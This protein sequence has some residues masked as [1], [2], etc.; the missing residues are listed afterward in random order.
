MAKQLNQVSVNLAFT[1][2]TKQAKAQ[3]QD[4]Q[5]QLKTIT[6]TSFT[7]LGLKNDVEGAVK[8]AAQLSTHLQKATNVK[9]GTLD[10]SKLN[11][12]LKQSGVSLDEYASKLRTLGP[13]GQ[14]AFMSLTQSVAN[15]EVPL[16]RT[17]ALLREMGTT[18]ANTARWQIS[19][20][21]LHG[22]MGAIQSAYGYAQD[23][24]ES[25]NNI[26]IVTGQ[27]TDQM[28]RFANEAQQAA[29][30]L[31][32]TTTAYTNASLIYYQQGLNEQQVKE[33]ADIT[34][35]MANIARESAEVVSDQLTAVWN[36]FY[37]EGGQSLEHYADAM[38]ALGAATASSTSE[39]AG[40]LE[41]FAS[42]ADMIGLSF[43]NAS[44]ALA[45]ITATTRQSEDVV[46]TALKTI[47]AR[48]QGLSL[49][50]TLEDGTNLNKY[51]EALNKVG[52]SIYDAAG[53]L[54]DMD[55][56]LAEMGAKWETLN[57]DQQVALAQ[58][59]AGV[60]QY[61]QLVS[62]MDNFDF[63][64]QNLRTAQNSDGTLNAQAE[65]YAESWEAAQKR[66][67]A[68]AEGVFNSLLKDDFFIDMLNNIEK[69]ISFV[70]KLIDSLG[71][72]KGVLLTLG[73]ILTKTFSAQ[74]AQN[75][76]SL[77]YN[78][79]MSTKVGRESEAKQKKAF[80][81]KQVTAIAQDPR[82]ATLTEQAQQDA[83]RSQLTLQQQLLENAEKMSTEELEQN[84]ILI[85]RNRILQEQR[86]AAVKNT[87]NAVKNQDT[88]VSDI[89]GRGFT[90]GADVKTLN[91]DIHSLRV[92]ATAIDEISNKFA[93][94]GIT[95][96]SS[97]AEVQELK[98]QIGALKTGDGVIDGF[99]QDFMQLEITSNNAGDEIQELLGRIKNLSNQKLSNIRSQIAST[100]TE[101]EITK[102]LDSLTDSINRTTVA[103]R[104]ERVAT[105]AAKRANDSAVE[106]IQ[107]AKGAQSTWADTLVA[108]AG[109][110]MNAAMA[111]NMVGSVF[112]TIKDPDASGWEKFTS[113]LMTLG[114][115]IPTLISL[116]SSLK[117]IIS[118]ETVAK[119][120]NA[121]ATVAQYLAEKKLNQEKRK[122]GKVTRGNTQETI[123][124]TKEKI[125]DTWNRSALNHNKN[126]TRTKSG[127]YAV[128]GQKGFVSE[129]KAIEMAGKSATKVAKGFGL[130]AAG[131][132]LATTAIIVAVNT[133]NKHN[134]AAEEA[135]KLAV[136]ASEAYE[137]V[138]SA[139]NKFTS[140]LSAYED[141]QNGMKN[142]TRGTL[143][144]KEAVLK[145]N[146]ASM[147]LL[148]SYEDLQYTVD[149]DGLIKI[150]EDSLEDAKEAQMDL[151]KNAQISKQVMNQNARDA[152]LKADSKTFQRKKM[153][154]SSDDGSQIGNIAAA[155]ATGL[156]SGALIGAGIGALGGGGILSL[157]AAA[158]G[159]IVGGVVGAIT[160]VIGATTAGASSKSEEQVLK[161]L[162]NIYS[163]EGNAKFATDESFEKMLR[164]DLKLDDEALIKSL[165]ENRTATLDL[166]EEMATNT[167]Q[168]RLMNEQMIQSK[169]GEEIEKKTYGNEELSKELTE[170]MGASL[171]QR[172]EELYNKEYKDKAGGKTDKEI[173]KAYAEAMG[174]DVEKT[175]N[176]KGNKATY[177]DKQGNVV[178]E[179]LDD[180][181]A[182]RF[183]AQQK[184][185]EEI[186][187]NMDTYITAIQ[188]LTNSGFGLGENVG[189]AVGSFAGGNGNLGTLTAE[190]FNTASGQLGEYDKSSKSFTF[191]GVTFDDEQAKTL[192]Y[193][194]AEEFYNAFSQEIERV[195]NAWASMDLERLAGLDP[196]LLEDLSL[197]SAQAISNQLDK[198]E[199]GPLGEQGGK[200]FVDGLNRMIANV[201]AEDQQKALQQLA[202]ID[203]SSWDAMEQAEAIL[204][205]FGVEMDSSS[206][207]WKEFTENMRIAY[208]ATPDFSTLKQQ[209]QS[210]SGILN[211]LDFGS[212]ISDEDYE[213]L[214]KYNDEWERFFILQAD[215]TRKFIGNSD[216]MKKA[217]Q[218][219]IQ[220]QRKELE[221]RREI[222]EGVNEAGWGVGS[223]ASRVSLDWS[224]AGKQFSLD[225]TAKN[226]M[227]TDDE[228]TSQ[229]LEKLGYTDDV[230]QDMLDEYNEAVESGD[231]EAIKAA[232]ERLKTMYNGIDTFMS[233]SANYEQNSAELDEMM[234]STATNFV[235]LNRLY[236]DG[237][238]SADAYSKQ[239][240][241]LT[242]EFANQAKTLDEL[243]QIQSLDPGAYIEGLLRIGAE[244]SNCAD[245][246]EAYNNALS[247][248]NSYLKEKAQS[249]L[250][251]AIIIG[252]AADKY[253]LSAEEL[254]YQA[255]ALQEVNPEMKLT[256]EQAARLAVQNQRLNKGVADLHDNWADWKKTLNSTKKDS[257]DYAK[258]AVAL[259][260]TI[261]DLVGASEDLEL[262]TD[263][264]DSADNM[265]LL[266]KAS[267]GSI[268]AINE[269]GTVVAAETVKM[270]EYSTAFTNYGW[271][272]GL[273]TNTFNVNKENVLSGIN[274]LR[275]AVVNGTIAAGDAV[276]N[277]GGQTAASWAQSLNEMALATGMSVDE[278]NSLLSSMGVEA[279][280]VT[281]DVPQK[282]KVPVYRTEETVVSEDPLI[283]DTKT[284]QV[285]T[286]EMDGVIPVAQINMGT[287][288]DAPDIK[289]VGSGS[290]SPSAT[291]G[292]NS[293]GGGGGKKK[294]TKKKED[295]IERYHVVNKEMD[296]INRKME[297][298]AGAKDAAFGRNKLPY[299][300]Q[301]ID[302]INDLIDK[303]Q[304]YK[305]EIE[306]NLALDK[307]NLAGFGFTDA[308]ADGILENWEQVMEE[309]LRIYNEA[310]EAYDNGTLDEEAFQEASDKYE[311][312]KKFVEQYEETHELWEEA[313]AREEE[314]E[315]ERISKELEKITTEIEFEVEINQRDLDKLEY[316]IDK[317][318]R[319][320]NTMIEIIDKL[321]TQVGS[322]QNQSN[323]YAEGI[324]RIK[325]N[326]AAEGRALTDE[327]QRKIWEYE[328]ALLDINNSLMDMVETVENSV[329]EEFDRL[330]EEIQENIDRFDTYNSM[331]D[332][333]NNIIKL[334]GRQTKD[335]M[336]LMKLSA[337]QTDIAMEKLNATNDK[338]LAQQEAQKDAAEKLANARR[339]GNQADIDYWEKQYEEITKAVEESHDAMLGSWEEVLQAASDQFDLAIELTIQ[340]LKDA[341]SEYGLDGLADR[342][343]KAKTVNEQYLSQLDK[344]Y[345]LNKLIRQMEKSIDETD[346]LKAK[347]VLNDLLDETNEKLEK[348]VELSQYDLEYMQKKYDLELA[349][350][351]L[352]E[353]QNAKSTVRLSRDNE[354]NFGYVYTAD[355]D[356]IDDAQQNYE[357]KLYDIRTLSEEYIQE[358]SDLIIQNEQDLMDALASI[359]KTR[360]ETKEEYE[361][362][363]ERIT[364][365]YLDRDIYLRTELDKAV[366]N[367]G[368]VYSD[369]ILGQ[370]ENAATWEEAH[371]TLKDNTNAATDTMIEKWD[372]W[373][374]TTEDAMEEVGSSSET[375]TSDIESDMEDIGIATGN[376]ADDIDEQ[377]QNMITYIGNLMDKVEDWRREYLQAIQDMIEANERLTGVESG[378]SSTD[379]G[380]TTTTSKDPEEPS[381]NKSSEAAALAAEAQEI[382]TK[383]HKGQIK[384]TSAGW[385][386]SA[387]SAGYSE[388]AIQ[389]AQKA[390]NDSK[391][392]GGYSYYYD[393]A[394]KLAGSYDTGGYTG[395]WG[396]EGKLAFLH[397]KELILN[398]EDTSN[399]LSTIS[400]IRD[401]VSMIDSQ[402]SMA[403][404]FNMSATS[405]VASNGETLEQTVTI[406][407]EF[408]NATD[409][410]EIEEAFNNLVNR[411]SQYAN[412]K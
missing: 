26:R 81:D 274:S 277:L 391:A 165:V 383:V 359:D 235:E 369:T 89:L 223:G 385:K 95:T 363:V 35:K 18:L 34:I 332:H 202:S 387:R 320:V 46:G 129:S 101:Q 287:T 290:V 55:S 365:Y 199:L 42:I 190:E 184:A 314:L 29:K 390:F 225:G 283:K 167:S 155:A 157:P 168:T 82:M 310:A 403:S 134:K 171:D 342:Y 360:F 151:L 302:A 233:E 132:A 6:Q 114:M 142:L 28:A 173:Q 27:T 230:I 118:L 209:L 238:I 343:E 201:D 23:L 367:S 175:K 177:Y 267:Q 75:L 323:W 392:G 386:P 272:S 315:R 104:E 84:K 3:L 186:G 197:Q 13:Q 76:T 72:V 264:F 389:I 321:G 306:D 70:D 345:E 38:T 204:K 193:K 351:A 377:T 62:L 181:V 44:A 255:K 60:R 234:A 282:V 288:G 5:S 328:D 113:I 192:G 112:D 154:S 296:A 31:S 371:N 47:F 25:L 102:D 227:N 164:E 381:D 174:W 61:N 279:E 215:G 398:K 189:K 364:K 8:A 253:G 382:V 160:G 185:L 326:A 295:E 100:G 50:E 144:Y 220:Q 12:N 384:Q 236:A 333:Y 54:K 407:A 298:A 292:N 119:I 115:L 349:R 122:S 69:I 319:N 335:S 80:I 145:A 2:D 172:A 263:F 301:E 358:M 379:P 158:V 85:D 33:R 93:E 140:N 106:S 221:E 355:Q 400:F 412:R 309:Q 141:A 139:Y 247:T 399:L 276:T 108:F 317:L 97:D 149:S 10:F 73:T 53:G 7:G 303:H 208:L 131:V 339:S 176:L 331:L 275:D 63:Y 136:K 297:R 45:T 179:E 98:A 211:D 291:T 368:R 397:E 388:E 214:I 64:E 49:G 404:M 354:G 146:E 109:A 228:A 128:K 205:D 96:N 338:Y 21:I 22:F 375:F 409:H 327:E 305:A 316:V 219:N 259:T 127:S 99:I 191:N 239:L 293:G 150:D 285:G 289:Y 77:A 170:T 126:F 330:S 373:K 32:T 312:F 265:A 163:K 258:T 169:Y 300:Q 52:I 304:E 244:Y 318:G 125:K 357:D 143:E 178:A 88:A 37:E 344:E 92:N 240:S 366:E 17:N 90:A 133:Y 273:L 254:E 341:I 59:V 188:G 410:N 406:H 148:D 123:I 124:D 362:E 24:N 324:N 110:A 137:Q 395:V 361:A 251:A 270:L 57:K 405:G 325:A 121:A 307:Q 372:D 257:S 322:Y 329:M 11:Q 71:G 195:G 241:Y 107:K 120:A 337:Q 224:K 401:I 394:L 243:R 248:N 380:P 313:L 48:I 166:V 203:W 135:A 58:T 156:G 308:D 180:E 4:L 206:E 207:E 242:Q 9:T 41:K 147:A 162:E 1:A 103:R 20:S 210:I 271:N 374:T 111:L 187:G 346:N 15:S 249:E 334:S 91:K 350:I 246:L 36:N 216:E 311:E 153:D 117:S 212:I 378:G 231:E 14:Q 200:E 222:A 51:S 83:M 74:L 86:V 266:E 105:E 347:A 130:I 245:E 78:I 182:R 269:L 79:K 352:E 213:K 284:W 40:G 183:L 43:D 39:I 370:L 356:K 65:I 194:N 159:T 16:R 278:M 229:M 218:E 196:A 286:E 116:W 152:Q 280:V 348:G 353:A 232:E 226:L 30:A 87:E 66:V 67:K 68:A 217:T 250:E 408:P 198:I 94:L 138:A 256:A 260:K 402:A 56:I 376:L 161:S 268:D 261:A 262:P 411:A 252:E 19:S 281:T 340:K 299:I 237:E 336:L 396:P 294:S 393:E